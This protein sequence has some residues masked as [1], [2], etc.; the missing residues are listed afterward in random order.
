[1]TVFE[2]DGDRQRYV[3]WLLQFSDRYGTAFWA[4]CLMSNHVHFVAI[5][6]KKDSLARTF[7]SAHMRYTQYANA[8]HDRTGHLWQARYFSCVLDEA[9]LWEAV[10]YIELNPVRAGLVKRAEEHPWSSAR[11]RVQGTPDPLLSGDCPLF[12]GPSEW[13]DYLRQVQDPEVIKS[14]RSSTRTG[15]PF[16]PKEFVALMERILG[17]RLR[18]L[19]RGRPRLEKK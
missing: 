19:P 18:A 8:K 7:N 14:L 17:R 13:K 4:Y 1:M 5:P 15:R 2:D 6:K 16:G 10:R 3:Q 9:H 12:E 11:A